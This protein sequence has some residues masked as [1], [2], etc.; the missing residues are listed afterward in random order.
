MENHASRRDQ[1]V[2]HTPDT[3]MADA[4]LTHATSD[5]NL[6]TMAH[7]NT[8]DFTPELMLKVISA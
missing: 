3:K 1:N 7:A 8:V 2:A 4:K 6:C 5:R